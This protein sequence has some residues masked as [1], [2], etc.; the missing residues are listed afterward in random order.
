MELRE[1]LTCVTAPEAVHVHARS[2]LL[3][4]NPPDPTSSR[5]GQHN[6][7][8]IN[9]A[10]VIRKFRSNLTIRCYTKALQ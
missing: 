5:M 8:A 7:N 3:T 1:L 6:F 2:V 4:W 9:V 10:A